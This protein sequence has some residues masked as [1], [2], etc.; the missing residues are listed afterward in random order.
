MKT[1]KTP[2]RDWGWQKVIISALSGKPKKLVNQFTYLDSYISSTESDIN[3][4]LSKVWY[5]VNQLSNIGKYKLTDTIK[6][7]FFQA[8]TIH[9]TIWMHHMDA[10]KSHCEKARWERNKTAVCWLERIL[11]A[12]HTTKKA[13]CT[14]TSFPSHKTPKISMPWVIRL[15]QQGWNHLLW[16]FMASSTWI[17][18]VGPP[19]RTYRCSVQTLDATMKTC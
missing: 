3:I 4:N 10:H 5:V 13:A 15:E 2:H 16:S 18:S 11:E 12:A 1:N 7:N 19:A 8:V 6:R 9:I 17:P 14:D